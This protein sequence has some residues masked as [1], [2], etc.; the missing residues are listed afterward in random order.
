MIINIQNPRGRI[1]QFD[2]GAHEQILYLKQRIHAKEL[3][4][5]EQQQLSYNGEFLFTLLSVLCFSGTILED[6]RPIYS[7]EIPN[8]ATLQLTYIPIREINA[9]TSCASPSQSA[10][11][12]ETVK[13]AAFFAGA[14]YTA[15]TFWNYMTSKPEKEKASDKK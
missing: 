6:H 7:Y 15:Y 8:R 11:V 4:D 2:V 1:F 10:D 3:I 5:I 14:L 13:S 9:E 12:L